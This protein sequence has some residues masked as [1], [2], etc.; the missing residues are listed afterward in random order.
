MTKGLSGAGFDIDLS[1]GKARESSLASILCERSTKVEVKSD[2]K[3]RHTGNLFIEF[4]QPS[5]PSGI[6][7]TEAGWWAFEFLDDCWLALPTQRVKELARRAYR[8][9][10]I[11][12]GGDYNNYRGVLVPI[13]WVLNGSLDPEKG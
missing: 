11:R 7:T 1:E 3:C 10:R 9:G 2:K 12:Q 13:A 4:E 5:G 8:E 6:A